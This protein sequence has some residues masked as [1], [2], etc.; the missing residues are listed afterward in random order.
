MIAR[1]HK[2]TDAGNSG[3]PKRSCKV[4]L[5]S[6]K[7]KVLILIRNGKNLHAE[8]DEIYN[9]NESSLHDVTKEN[10]FTN[11]TLTT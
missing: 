10:K 4:L 3:C 6:E 8:V 9:E 5:L 7:V 2:I 1:K 11:S